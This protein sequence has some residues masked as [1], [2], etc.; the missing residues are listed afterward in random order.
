MPGNAL[1]VA[2]TLA[3]AP[4]EDPI[5]TWAPIRSKP[6]RVHALSRVARRDGPDLHVVETRTCAL[7]LTDERDIE[8]YRAAFVSLRE[9][10][11]MGDE[12]TALI[13]AIMADLLHLR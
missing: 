5:S 10:A 11:V 8:T 2:A 3:I 7:T 12:V 13:R 1:R 9:F 6:V 4:G